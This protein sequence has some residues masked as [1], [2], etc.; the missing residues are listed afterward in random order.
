MSI[1]DDQI[2]RQSET[3]YNQ[4]C[5]QWRDHAKFH[6][7]FG[8]KTLDDYSNIGIGKA[9]L[10]IA[11]GYSLEENI[12]TIKKYQDN[13]DIICVDKCL[14][15][16]IEHGVIPDY[17]LLCDANVSYE[18]YM[19]PVKDKL[20]NTALF[21]NVCANTKWTSNGNWKDIRFFVNMDILKSEEEFSSLSGCKNFIP[22]GTNVSNAQLVFLTQC[23]NRGFNNFFGY[24]KI[25]LIGYDY[26]WDNDGYYAFNQTGD[27]K[28]NYMKNLHLLD[29]RG[30]LV[31]T[32]NN[33]LFSAKWLEKYIK[34]FRIQAIQCSKR[35]IYGGFKFGDLEDQMQYCYKPDDSGK[36]RSLLQYKR[37]LAERQR[38]A[39]HEI[40]KIGRDHFKSVIRT[41]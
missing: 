21:S 3:A 16:L 1:S 36:V 20:E 19:E 7:R 41:T 33:L 10:A 18:T 15:P 34:T 40:F 27:G 17:V 32:S 9:I 8:Q 39:D 25:L 23:D 12:E 38:Q 13:V 30:E 11:N 31:F 4:W 29:H 22:A 37:E 2:R 14:K 35:S 6:S 28:I 24:D 5:E 26:S